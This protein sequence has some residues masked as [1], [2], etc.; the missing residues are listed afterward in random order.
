MIDN[1]ILAAIVTGGVTVVGFFAWLVRKV[2]KI[3]SEVAEL[4]TQNDAMIEDFRR[5]VVRDEA[6]HEALERKMDKLLEV[7]AATKAKLD[8]YISENHNKKQ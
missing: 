7:T 3:E 5:H 4:K 1:G 8:L 2:F 6:Q